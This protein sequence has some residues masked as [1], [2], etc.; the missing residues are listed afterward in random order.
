MQPALHQVLR[1]V[2]FVMLLLFC[3]FFGL[4]LA[5]TCLGYS[6]FAQ[7]PIIYRAAYES[8]LDQQKPTLAQWQHLTRATVAANGRKT[9]T[10]I[11]YERH[12]LVIT[13][14]GVAT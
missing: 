8:V 6:D 12:R 7:L 5:N 3:G 11:W 10:A 1:V 14:D 13:V 9:V 2:V 4:L